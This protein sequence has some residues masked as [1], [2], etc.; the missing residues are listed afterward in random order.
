MGQRGGTGRN[1]HESEKLLEK[2]DIISEG[3]IF[4]NKISKNSKN[5]Y[6]PL[7]FPQTFANFLKIS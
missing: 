3:S 6:F 4:S 5:F 7:N 1:S 2:Y